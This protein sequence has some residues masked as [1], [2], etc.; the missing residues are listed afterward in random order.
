MTEYIMNYSEYIKF[1]CMDT[2]IDKEYKEDHIMLNIEG[3]DNENDTICE[4]S[5]KWT[6]L[7]NDE[8]GFIYGINTSSIFALNSCYWAYDE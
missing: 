3:I 2:T 7:D 4:Y 6:N 8:T 5:I 1:F